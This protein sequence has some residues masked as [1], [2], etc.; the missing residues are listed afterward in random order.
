MTPEQRPTSYRL[1]P[2]TVE[3]IKRLSEKWNVSQPRAIRFLV[4]KA[5][6]EDWDVRAVAP[7]EGVRARGKDGEE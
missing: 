1:E 7:D 3:R 4:D 2:E 6:R 5:V